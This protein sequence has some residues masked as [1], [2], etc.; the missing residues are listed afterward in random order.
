MTS[1]FHHILVPVDGSAPSLTALKKAVQLCA[2]C[3]ATLTIFHAVDVNASLSSFEQVST[4]GYIPADL[5]A[6]GYEILAAAVQ[7]VA[8]PKASQQVV[9]V[10]NPADAILTYTAQHDIDLIVM[11]NRGL[12][13]FKELLLGSVSHSVLLRSN[14]PVLIVK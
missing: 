6:K 7:Y 1:P 4:G 5:I 3:G 10:G 11:G 13:R 12:S 2:C 9:H 14:V 8:I